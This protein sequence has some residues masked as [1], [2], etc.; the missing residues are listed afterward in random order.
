[1]PSDYYLWLVGTAGKFLREGRTM[2]E[3]IVDRPGQPEIGRYL[4]SKDDA[5]YTQAQQAFEANHRLYQIG[6]ALG[7]H[8]SEWAPLEAGGGRV[9]VSG[10]W[11]PSFLWSADPTATATWEIPVAAAATYRLSL[12]YPADPNQTHATAARVRV[13]EGDVVLQEFRVNLQTD[14]LRWAA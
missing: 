5:V 4:R 11:N 13:T 1:M 14:T 6:D 8:A 10:K 3:R 12:R 2:P 7:K 9:R